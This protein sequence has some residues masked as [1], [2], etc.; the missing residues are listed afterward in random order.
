MKKFLIVLAASIGM[1]ATFVPP[2][3]AAQIDGNC[4]TYANNTGSKKVEICVYNA[5]DANNYIWG[6]TTFDNVPG[7]G[8]P[9]AVASINGDGTRVWSSP[10]QDAGPYCAGKYP[11]CNGSGDGNYNITNMV[12]SA[13]PYIDTTNHYF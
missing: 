13:T 5:S 10:N 3:S 8:L 2:A 6:K 1:L 7:F 9:Y 12:N 4:N 11:A